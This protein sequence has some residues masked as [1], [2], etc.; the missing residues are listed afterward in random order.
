MPLS[1]VR[2]AITRYTRAVQEANIDELRRITWGA[3]RERFSSE[4]TQLIAAHLAADTCQHGSIRVSN[5]RDARFDAE[6][7]KMTATVNFEH[8]PALDVRFAIVALRGQWL[9]VGADTLPGDAKG[10]SHPV[11]RDPRSQS[12]GVGALVG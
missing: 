6:Q 4:K 2:D 8:A 10:P 12:P 5:F 9:L 1:G 3:L 11:A 7:W